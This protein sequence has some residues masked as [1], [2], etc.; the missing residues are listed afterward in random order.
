M[1]T[2]VRRDRRPRYPAPG[3]ADRQRCASRR[4]KLWDWCIQHSPAVLAGS[5]PRKQHAA[6]IGEHERVLMIRLGS[7][8]VR[9]REGCRLASGSGDT[10]ETNSRI[11]QPNIASSAGI[12]PCARRSANVAPST[13]CMTSARP[14]SV[15]SRP[16]SPAIFG[17]LNAASTCASRANRASHSSSADTVEGRIL[18][19]TSR[20]NR[21]SCARCESQCGPDGTLPKRPQRRHRKDRIDLWSDGRQRRGPPKTPKPPKETVRCLRCFR[22]DPF[23]VVGGIR[24]APP[25]ASTRQRRS[26]RLPRPPSQTGRRSS[27]HW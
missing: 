13:N 6:P 24:S 27:A 10:L 14:V 21:A 5:R 11:T 15:S 26:W 12:A 8:W 2:S 23:R 25:V 20:F 4:E 7:P 9:R 3:R 22:W 1:R 19:A 16:Y 17:W 18:I